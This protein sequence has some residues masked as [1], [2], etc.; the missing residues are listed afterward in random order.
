M[1]TA[2]L[3]LYTYFRLE[4]DDPARRS[5]VLQPMLVL[6]LFS[7]SYLGASLL[8]CTLLL[9]QYEL[10][11]DLTI[12]E[13]LGGSLVA[14]LAFST[15]MSLVARRHAFSKILERMTSG[16]T[17]FTRIAASFGA[18]CTQMGIQR[19]SLREATFGSAFSLSLNGQQVVA[20]SPGM[21]SLLSSEE[22]E[23]VLAH[24]LSH[25]KNGDSVAKGA[26]RLAR[27]AFPFDPVLRL[28]EAAVHRER[29]LWA[30]RVAVEFT[31][32]PL[33]LASALVKANSG[34]SSATA[35]HAAGLFVGGSGR[36]LLSLYPNLERRV[37]FLLTLAS[38]MKTIAAA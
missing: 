7:W 17:P 23:A 10:L 24:E 29:E 27:L 36:G 4:K 30:D 21:A 28:V 8:L 20:I 9:G 22:T 13:V 1:A 12:T 11:P 3:G 18:L 31:R 16:S 6:S 34:A 15:V 14:S 19:A 37:N 35:I 5:R 33:A 32:R 26:A 2:Y 25:I 38:R